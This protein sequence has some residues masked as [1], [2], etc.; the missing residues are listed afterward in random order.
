MKKIKKNKLHE[1]CLARHYKY[2]Y[3]CDPESTR[4]FTK[5]SDFLIWIHNNGVMNI[6][7]VAIYLTDDSIIHA[8]S[9]PLRSFD[10]KGR[11]FTI[12]ESFSF[13]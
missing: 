2:I 10:P 4:D 6:S 9:W 7:V 3:I 12:I 5:S 11:V 13:N 1:K 8:F